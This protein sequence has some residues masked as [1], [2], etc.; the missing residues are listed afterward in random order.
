MF[1]PR[2]RLLLITTLSVVVAG[3][4]A[5][6]KQNVVS[7][8]SRFAD[9][10]ARLQRQ[11]WSFDL[12]FSEL[13]RTALANVEANPKLQLHDQIRSV[14]GGLWLW[15]SRGGNAHIQGRHDWAFHF[16]G[17]GAFEGYWDVG[18]SAALT[19]EQLD[20]KNPHNR[21]DKDDLA[22]TLLGARWMELA[23]R[24]DPA[25]ARRWV[26]LWATRQL[27]IERSLPPL[28][29]GQMPKG[30]R[31]SAETIA[32]IRRDIDAALHLPN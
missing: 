23:T 11:G 21:F 22:A 27:T 32:A 28:R 2:F 4:W 16:I 25:Q 15:M 20:A 1:A 18:R 7:H 30:E 29:Y 13:C 6:T 9:Q 24:S 17:G 3:A 19:K 31:A 5:E 10:A 26:E 8:D 12:I 14:F